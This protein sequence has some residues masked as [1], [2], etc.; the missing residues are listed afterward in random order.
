MKVRRCQGWRVKRNRLGMFDLVGRGG[1]VLR[2]WGQVKHVGRLL[3][4][5]LDEIVR[6][7][8]GAEKDPVPSPAADECKDF[9]SAWN[10]SLVTEE[11]PGNEEEA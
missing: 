9:L 5:L 3:E 2:D 6:L 11:S 10:E 7:E 8:E 1:V 4:F